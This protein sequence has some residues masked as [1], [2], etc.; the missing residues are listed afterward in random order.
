[1]YPEGRLP[2]QSEEGTGRGEQGGMGSLGK[3]THK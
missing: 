1:M 2:A 3:E